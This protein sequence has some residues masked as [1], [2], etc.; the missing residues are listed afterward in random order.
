MQIIITLILMGKS[1]FDH[2]V[3]LVKDKSV[4]EIFCENKQKIPQKILVSP[5]RHLLY[6]IYLFLQ[7]KRF[8]VSAQQ[9]QNKK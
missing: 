1:C 3:D 2:N 5:L 9:Q 8:N 7:W 6:F 4:P